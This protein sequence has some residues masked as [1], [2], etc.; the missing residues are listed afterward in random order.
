MKSKYKQINTIPDEAITVYEAQ[1]IFFSNFWS[2]VFYLTFNLIGYF[3]YDIV[4][5]YA[6]EE[7]FYRFLDFLYC[8]IGLFVLFVIIYQF[9]QM[10]R[11]ADSSAVEISYYLT[12]G[13]LFS[14]GQNVLYVIYEELD[15]VKSIDHLTV[16]L[17]ALGGTITIVFFIV[18]LGKSYRQHVVIKAIRDV[19]EL[20][21]SLV[22]IDDAKE[23][24]D[25]FLRQQ[26]EQKGLKCWFG[27][28]DDFS[29]A[30]LISH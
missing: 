20:K 29:I 26:Y 6:A 11:F 9:R 1:S 13:A 19:N 27:V 12:M 2:A 16:A 5:F 7:G 28:A 18:T 8:F 14:V 21:H 25:R 17:V 3:L 22:S 10:V 4:D 24:Y 23:I 30:S 15:P